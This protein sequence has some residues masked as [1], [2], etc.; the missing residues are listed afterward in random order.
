MGETKGLMNKSIEFKQS[1]YFDSFK[2]DEQSFF[3]C[4]I[5]IRSLLASIIIKWDS[6]HEQPTKNIPKLLDITLRLLN[7]L[8]KVCY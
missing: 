4:I 1:L 8:N 3:K 6:Y 5:I 2:I 7:L